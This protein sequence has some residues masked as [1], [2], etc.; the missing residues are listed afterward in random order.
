MSAR[1]DLIDL[2]DPALPPEWDTYS[3]PATIDAIESGATVLL[4]DTYAEQAEPVRGLRTHTVTLVLVVPYVSSPEADDALDVA[5]DV[6]RPALNELAG[7]FLIH[8][9]EAT[10]S[11]FVAT[12]PA[13]S[14]PVTMKTKD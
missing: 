1:Q 9:T 4:V 10:R 6:L 12:Y 5:W 7:G 8:W 2:L 3:Y 14:I 13:L 11:T